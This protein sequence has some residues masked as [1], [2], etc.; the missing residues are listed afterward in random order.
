MSEITIKTKQNK[1]GYVPAEY[2]QLLKSVVA[3]DF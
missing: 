3:L 1:F 2:I